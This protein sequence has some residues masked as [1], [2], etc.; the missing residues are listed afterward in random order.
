[1]AQAPDIQWQKALGGSN[2]ENAN[3]IIETSDSGFLVIG[4]TASNDGDITENHGSVDVWLLKLDSLGS[5]EWQ[6]SYGGTAGEEAFQI[7]ETSDNGFIFIGY[8]T[9]SDGDLTANHGGDD[10]WVVK[11]DEA[12]VIEWQK[13]YG[14]SSHEIGYS[15]SQNDIGYVLCGMTSSN[16]GDVSGN[17]GGQDVWVV[18]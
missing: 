5:L 17:H 4:T 10:V 8:S 15:I 3:S 6:K 18:N 9:S 12:G 13:S 7:Q 11:I 16:N 14:G 1:M 2:Y